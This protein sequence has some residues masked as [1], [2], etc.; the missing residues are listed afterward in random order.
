[1]YVDSCATELHGKIY[2]RDLLRTTRREG[3]KIVHTTVLNLN[4]YCTKQEIEAL[5]LAFKHKNNLKALYSLKDELSVKQGTSFGAVWL[6][7]ETARKIGIIDALG[8]TRDGKL[9]LWQVIARV[10]EQGSRL[11]AVRLAGRTAACDILGLDKFNEDHL[12]D[13]LDWLDENQKKIENRLF[14]TLHAAKPPQLYLYDVTSSYLEGTKNEL[15]AFGYNR[16]GKRGK[17]QIVIGLLCN[18]FGQPLSIEVF[19]GNMSDPNTVASQIRKVAGRLGGGEVTFVGDRGMLKSKQIQDLIDNDFHYITAITKPQIESL[20]KDGTME[21]SLFDQNLSE[22]VT[23]NGIRY[24]TRRN[25]IRAKEIQASRND[26]LKS[27]QKYVDR[28]N[29]YLSEHSR[30]VLKVALRKCLEYCKKLHLNGYVKLSLTDR[31]ISVSIDDDEL[32]ELSKLDGC[33]ALKTDLPVEVA[34]KEIINARY[35]DLTLVEKAFRTCKTVE[36]ELRP[37]NVRLAS[38][39]RGHAFVVMLAYRLTQELANCWESLNMRVSE[40]LDELKSLCTSEITV[41]DVVMNKILIPNELSSKLLAS[42]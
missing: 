27:L 35:K 39:T 21:M 36:L 3:G 30:A 1:M 23:A 20:L 14:K 11:S 40:G 19:N 22:I 28:L 24:I 8:K 42:A 29:K 10:I 38:R 25:P 4:K 31:I 2:D 17:R 34:T 5:K 12:Y 15:A 33:Y 9:A 18:E 37:I 41:R 6:L 32:A 7:F 16:D 26:K 13:N